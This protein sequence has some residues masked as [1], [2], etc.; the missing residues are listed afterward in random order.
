[1]VWEV[2]RCHDS[3]PLGEV[4]VIEGEVGVVVPAG[5]RVKYALLESLTVDWVALFTETL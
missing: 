4:M 2:P 5:V 1:M 3:P